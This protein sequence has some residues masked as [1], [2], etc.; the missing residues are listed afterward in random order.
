MAEGLYAKTRLTPLAPAAGTIALPRRRAPPSIPTYLREVYHW[1]YLDPRNVRLLDRDLVVAAILWGNDA[2]L[3]RAAFAEFVP[4]QRILQAS[5][6]YGG[7]IP[8]LAR[9]LGPQGRLDVIDV[10]PIQV[11][12]CREKLAPYPWARVRRADARDPGGGP[13]DAV[14]CY[15]LLHELPD[16]FKSAVVDALLGVV[17][18]GGSVVFV[19]YHRPPPW[20][21]LGWVRSRVFDALE[22]L[23]KGLWGREIRDFAG[24][25]VGFAWHKETYFGGLYQKVVAR[26]LASGAGGRG[27][28]HDPLSRCQVLEGRR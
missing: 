1:A 12:R 17:R 20:H 28:V 27:G 5:H 16:G 9:L 18:P 19:D 21:P 24:E 3:R 4:S 8:G 15:F 23:A 26:R 25:G 10:A 2:R 22:P 14:S 6:V 13:Y 11:A 7:M